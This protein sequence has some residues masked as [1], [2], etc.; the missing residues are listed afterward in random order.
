MSSRASS[1]SGTRADRACR[2]T[3]RGRRGAGNAAR[4][5][6]RAR[7]QRT[8]RAGRRLSAS[9]GTWTGTKPISFAYQWV[10]CGADGGQPDGGNCAIVSGATEHRYRLVSADVG[11]RMRVRVTATNGD[12]SRTAASNP[13]AVVGGPPV[14]TSIPTR[15]RDDDGRL[16]ADCR[17][18]VVDR[19]PADLVLVPLAALQHAGRRAA[20]RSPGRRVRRTG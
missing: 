9:T 13:T 12:G 5:H 20:S 14:N 11:F 18:R 8:R 4:E 1:R 10:R 6:R 7:D 2:P 3:R 16:G 19:R 15:S 17:S